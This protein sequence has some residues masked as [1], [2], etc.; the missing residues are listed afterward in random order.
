MH[1]RTPKYIESYG[2][3]MRENIIV[4]EPIGYL[5]MI[6]F[7][8]HAKKI[9]TDSVGV[10]KEVSFMKK[11]CI[12]MRDQTEWVETVENGWNVIVGTDK[13]K[14]EDNIKNF[15]PQKEQENIFCNGKVAEKIL[16]ILSKVI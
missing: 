13:S 4:I 6:N 8:M 16:S 7:E 2:L 11:P 14:I 9:V 3:N 15:E 5:D 1:P 12:T 10:Q